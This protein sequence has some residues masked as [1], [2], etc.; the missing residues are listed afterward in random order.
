MSKE[1]NWRTSPEPDIDSYI[2]ETI[3]SYRAAN[4][5]KWNLD[6][7]IAGMQREKAKELLRR[8]R[9]A[10]KV[11]ETKA[12]RPAPRID[13]EKTELHRK[14]EWLS[15]FCKQHEAEGI[16]EHVGITMARIPSS[17]YPEGGEVK[18]FYVGGVTPE[19][20][21]DSPGIQSENSFT[22]RAKEMALDGA[23]D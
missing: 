13:I 17:G 15:Y 16:R 10:R 19:P 9:E 22:A 21:V 3:A 2:E 7:A 12:A 6:G 14:A 5:P 20:E 8:E 1:F 11:A 4:W 18:E 23:I